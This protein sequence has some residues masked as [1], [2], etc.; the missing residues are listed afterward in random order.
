MNVGSIAV[1]VLV[2]AA[3]GVAGFVGGYYFHGAAISA[4]S[5]ASQT[6]SITAAG[7]LNTLFPQVGRALA[8]ATPGVSAPSAA[9]QYMGSLAA[10]GAVSQLHQTFDVA[11]A[12]DFRL[13][14][15]L[16][17]PTYA[18]WEVV[19]AST[20]EVLVYDPTVAGFSGINTTNWASKLTAPGV[21]LGV[22]NQSTDPNGYN[23][24]F[25]LQLEGMLLNGSLG[26]VYGHF[27]TTPVGGFAEP[28]PTTAKVELETQVATLIKSHTVSAFITYRSYAI[29]HGLSYVSLDPRVGLGSTDANDLSFYAQASTTILVANGTSTVRGAPVL[30]AATVP[31]NAPNPSLGAAFIDYLVSPAGAALIDS[32]GFTPVTPALSADVLAPVPSVLSPDVIPLPS[33]LAGLIS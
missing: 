14:P 22:A 29:S 33:S 28:N 7:T 19:F 23:G 2:A 9:Q 5:T 20:P 25:V 27:F 6:L 26:V 8:N 10:L 15:G 13:I 11:A 3:T 18:S 31:L 21:V 1:V 17:E 24:I 30:F 32:D 16:L 4:A 12:A